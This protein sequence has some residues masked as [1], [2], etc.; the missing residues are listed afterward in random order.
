MPEFLRPDVANEMARAVGVAIEAGDAAARLRRA[1]VFGLIEL[2]L[3]ERRRAA[4]AA[5]PAASD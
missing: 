5:L 4:A 1:A 3:R 2:M